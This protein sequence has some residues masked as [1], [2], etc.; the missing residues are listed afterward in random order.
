MPYQTISQRPAAPRQQGQVAPGYV[1]YSRILDANRPGAKRMA[2][3]LAGNV[4]QQG[5]Q[6]QGAIQQAGQQ[7]TDKV[8]AGTLT[9]SNP[10]NSTRGTAAAAGQGYAQ[11][12]AAIGQQANANRREYQGPKDWAGAGINTQGLATQA[13]QAGAAAQGLTSMGGRA[14]QLRQQARGPYGAGMSSLDAALAGSGL[15]GRG[16]ELSSMYGNLSQQLIDRQAASGREVQGAQG[17]S[18]AAYGAY[19]ADVAR[20]NQAAQPQAPVQAPYPTPTSLP[21]PNVDGVVWDWDK[22][23]GQWVPTYP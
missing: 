16:Q 15:G 7:F 21:P 22:Q 19:E 12:G 20:W 10:L 1:P 5:Q 18:N 13:A 23:S 3:Q 8:K 4:Q 11:A 9:Y 14:A 2:D 6:A 17:A